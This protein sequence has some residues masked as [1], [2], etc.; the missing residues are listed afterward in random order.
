MR[1]CRGCLL[2]RGQ[3]LARRASRSAQW[4]CPVHGQGR[5]AIRT[6]A[7]VLLSSH[8]WR[9]QPQSDGLGPSKIKRL[10][11]LP[12]RRSC[13]VVDDSTCQVMGGV[14]AASPH[15][16][17]DGLL[18]VLCCPCG[19]S[20]DV[21]SDSCD[22]ESSSVPVAPPLVTRWPA[23]YLRLC[24]LRQPMTTTGPEIG[25]RSNANEPVWVSED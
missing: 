16:E 12:S 21:A 20:L 10:G 2:A 22:S 4:P 7:A 24:C 19:W 17:P 13:P 14:L 1:T 3:L 8:A 15:Q 11:S 25:L 23:H 18:C 5:S 6:Q 9:R